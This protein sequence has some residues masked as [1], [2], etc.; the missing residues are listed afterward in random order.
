[1]EILMPEFVPILFFYV[2]YVRHVRFRHLFQPS[3]FPLL[4]I[5]AAVRRGPNAAYA[6]T[7]SQTSA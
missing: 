2:Y 3:A 7:I 5:R 6:R 4:R 1:M